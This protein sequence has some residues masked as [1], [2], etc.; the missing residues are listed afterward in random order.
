MQVDAPVR[1]QGHF[2][3]DPQARAPERFRGDPAGTQALDPALHAHPDLQPVVDR[4][5][6]GQAVVAEGEG[7]GLPVEVEPVG[8]AADGRA[9]KVEPGV[10]RRGGTLGV[11]CSA[12]WNQGARSIRIG[13]AM[14]EGGVSGAWAQR[15]RLARGGQEALENG[16]GKII[17]V[18]GPARSNR[19]SDPG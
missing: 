15:A 2:R 12:V 6:H 1:G 18:L 4:G 9:G 13:A 17:P 19:H 11:V 5:V 3:E 10:P 8:G 16:H 14:N 7:Q